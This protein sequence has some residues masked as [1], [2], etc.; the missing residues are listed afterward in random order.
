MEFLQNISKEITKQKYYLHGETT[1]EE[2]FRGVAKE[3]ASVE[4]DK[5]LQD[6][7][8]NQFYMQLDSGKFIPGGRILANARVDSKLKNYNNCFTI[9]V[10]DSM[11][12]IT[13]SLTEYMQILKTGGGVGNEISKLRPK[14]SPISTGGNSSG[15]MSFLEIYDSASKTIRVGGGRRGASIAIMRCD[16]PDIEDFITYKQGDK[17]GKLTQFNISV[18]VSDEFMRAVE[19]DEDWD[20]VWGGKVYK[21]IKA[22]YL[23]NLITENA[24]QHNEPGVLFV[25]TVERFNTGSWSFKMDR[26]NPCFT[27]DTI[28][29]TADGRNGVTIKELAEEQLKFPVDHTFPVYSARPKANK[30]KWKEEIKKAVAFKTGTRKIIEVTLSDGSVIRCTPEHL[31]ALS[32]GD[33]VEAQQSTGKELEKFYSFSNKNTNK[34]YRTINSKSNGY[35]RQYRMMWDYKYGK[36]DGKVNN[37]DHKDENSTNDTYSNLQL[38]PVEE[39]K[40]KLRLSLKAN[41]PLNRMTDRDRLSIMQKHKNILGNGKKY[42]WSEE[43]ISE[44]LLKLPTVPDPVDK[45]VYMDD[46]VFV[47]QVK[48]T[49]E[50][51]DVYDL[52]V[53]DNHNFYIIT[54]TDDEKFLNCSGVL[55]HNCGEITMPAYSLCCLSSINLSRFVI[56]PFTNEAYIDIPALLNTVKLGVRFLDNVL[57]ATDYPLDKIEDFSKLWRRI[58]LG[59]TGL[60]DMFAMLMIKYGSEDSIK[61]SNELSSKMMNKAYLSSVELAKEKGSFPSYDGGEVLKGEFIKKLDRPVQDGIAKYGLRNIGLLTIAPTGTTSFSLGENCSSGIEPIFSIKYDRTVKDLSVA[62]Q[63]TLTTE[64]VYDYA[65]LKFLQQKENASIQYGDGAPEYFVTTKDIDPRA[66]IKVQQAWQNHIDHSIS[67]TL[68]LP[69]GTSK[70]EYDGLFHEAWKAGLKGFTT[71]NPDGSMK[72]ILDYGDKKEEPAER[73]IRHNAP[74]RPKELP[75]DIYE[76]RVKSVPM[77]VLVGLL[78]GE[79]YEFFCTPNEGKIIDVKHHKT[80]IIKK[81]R[82]GRYDLIITNGKDKV[83]A[84]DIGHTFDEEFRT[85]ARLGSGMLRHGADIKFVMDQLQKTGDMASFQKA[86]SRALKNYLTDGKIKTYGEAP[87]CEVCKEELIMKDGCSMCPSCGWSKCS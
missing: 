78:H 69:P 30:G 87:K 26:V 82:R 41:N 25:D 27:G 75:C 23:Y 37:V 66:S 12:S 34:S 8:E 14:G 38:I 57:D 50:T 44:E 45:N 63:E 55:V 6:Y 18:G 7:Y 32:N 77:L 59:I 79:P 72:G 58:G 19:A 54:K 56:N 81:V 51:E 48:V 65:W 76:V 13:R 70:E 11:E 10:E 60:G 36:Y 33:Y 9:D 15:P 80:G 53:E 3:I 49:N 2:L 39:H 28:I 20:L 73:I 31:L 85:I 5:G 21:T 74:R 61:V 62:G 68:N 64:T 67:K 52:T 84:E 24:Y 22:R 40:E 35:V 83:I 46:R 1:K 71:F 86:T 42:N 29:A 4:K 17:N 16:H 43:K 47:E